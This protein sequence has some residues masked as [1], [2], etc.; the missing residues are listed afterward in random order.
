MVSIIIP[1][2]NRIESLLKAIESISRQTNNGYEIIVVDD[3]STDGTPEVLKKEF[4]AVSV[5]STKE[6]LGPTHARNI[7]I[8]RSS[9][10]YL[11][12]L[13]S[14]VILPDENMVDKMLDTFNAVPGIGSLGGEIVIHEALMDRAYGRQITWNAHT[15]RVVAFKNNGLVECDYLATCNC[16][17]KKEFTDKIGGFDE[18]F[19]FGAEDMDFGLKLRKIGLKNYVAHKVAVHHLHKNVGRYENETRH[20]QKTR[21]QFAKKHYKMSRLSMMF[22][23]DVF[24]TAKFFL[25]LPF[26]LMFFVIMKRKITRQNLMGGWYLLQ[27]YFKVFA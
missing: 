10:E 18:Q 7:G 9:G 5:F 23:V 12:F 16:F 1:S 14:D 3:G 26:K 25:L 8:S 2:Y 15:K 20:Y 11:W 17:T 24:N 22:L 6:R 27:C 21:M 13:D 4:N 19:I